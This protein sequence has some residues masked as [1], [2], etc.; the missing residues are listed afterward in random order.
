MADELT[1]RRREYEV[2]VIYACIEST[3]EARPD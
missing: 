2:D 3:Y 1:S